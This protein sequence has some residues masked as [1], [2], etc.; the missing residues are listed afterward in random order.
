MLKDFIHVY[1]TIE[2]VINSS[3]SKV[4][5]D[6]NIV[7]RGKEFLFLNIILNIILIFVKTTTKLQTENY[8]TIYYIIPKVYK[9]YNRLEGF[10]EKYNISIFS[11]KII[12][13]N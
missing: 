2:I 9:I 13:K 3:K 7:L 5:K 6:K 12:L 8:P 10:K 11:L 4:F 1:E